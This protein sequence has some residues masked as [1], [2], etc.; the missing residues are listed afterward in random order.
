MDMVAVKKPEAA[1]DMEKDG[2]E[3]ALEGDWLY[4]K[5][6][7]LGGDDGIAVAYALAL[8]E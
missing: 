4:A 1:I 3:L 7:S 5:D 6:T 2:L 8:L